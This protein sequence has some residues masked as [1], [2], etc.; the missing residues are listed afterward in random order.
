MDRFTV[1]RSALKKREITDFQT[2]ITTARKFDDDLVRTFSHVPP[3]WLYETVHDD[4][5][6][7][8]AYAGSYDIYYDIW[9]AQIW[10]SMRQCRIMLNEIVRTHILDGFASAPRLFATADYTAIFQHSSDVLLEIRDGIL[11]SVPQHIGYVTR[12]P[13]LETQQVPINHLNN[14]SITDLLKDEPPTDSP[15]SHTRLAPT[16]PAPA[17]GGHF[18]LWPL[19]LAGIT[20]VT[21]PDIRQLIITRLQYVG[22]TMGIMQ[23]N[24][25]MNF[26]K[27]GAAM[28]DRNSMRDEV[29][30]QYDEAQ[31]GKQKLLGKNRET[32]D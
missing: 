22:E 7:K 2:I 15:H 9:V 28:N 1:F 11:R 24:A 18:L 30:K 14:V 20:R 10:N 5:S 32:D 13:S 27:A 21:T 23:A 26:L 6:C 16:I 4:S 8:L 17:I 19:Y 31:L 3:G 29:L 12:K 25:L